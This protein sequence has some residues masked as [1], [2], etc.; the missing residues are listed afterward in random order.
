MLSRHVLGGI[1]VHAIQ[2]EHCQHGWRL[3]RRI[4]L[5]FLQQRKCLP[6]HINIHLLDRVKPKP[7]FDCGC[8]QQ[9]MLVK[10]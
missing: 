7:G 1:G 8:R 4:Q 10:R 3:Q 9:L 5:Q 2:P 6:R